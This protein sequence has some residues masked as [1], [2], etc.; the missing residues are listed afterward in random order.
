MKLKTNKKIMPRMNENNEEPTKF[1]RR[2]STLDREQLEYVL[3][4][5][6]TYGTI[7]FL[8]SGVLASVTYMTFQQLK[9]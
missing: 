7:V 4:K 8:V 9:K 3:P 5:I 6:L 2:N 1:T